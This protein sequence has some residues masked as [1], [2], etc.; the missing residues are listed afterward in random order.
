M[1]NDGESRSRCDE[2]VWHVQR[3]PAIAGI[4]L[5]N[6]ISFI[7]LIMWKPAGSTPVT[8]SVIII[9][10][11]KIGWSRFSIL[12]LYIRYQKKK[13]KKRRLWYK[14]GLFMLPNK[15]NLQDDKKL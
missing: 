5:D 11:L 9:I 10:I 14:I 8:L 13:K 3:I 2:E 4:Y 15:N 6:T 7:Y 12:V 1:Y